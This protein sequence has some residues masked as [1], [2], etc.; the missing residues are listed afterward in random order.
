MQRNMRRMGVLASAILLL[1]V[2]AAGNAS[3]AGTTA[4][5]SISNSATVNFNV[6]GVGQTVESSE[7][8]NSVPG[9]G[10]ATVFTVD[11]KVD[12]L[13]SE[14]GG[15]FT[16]TRPGAVDQVLTFTVENEGNFVQDFLLT[17]TDGSGNTFT[18]GG[19]TDTDDFDATAV[20]PP[21]IWIDSDLSGDFD[22]TL[23]TE[24]AYLDNLAVDTP[25]TVFVVRNIAGTEVDG[26]ASFITLDAQAVANSGTP[27]SPGAPLT[28]D[29]GTA[30]TLQDAVGSEQIVFADDAATTSVAD[31]A[32]DGHHSAIDGYIIR[33]AQLTIQKTA[34]V[35]SDPFSSSNP[36]AIPGAIVE[37]TIQ[38]DNAGAATETAAG[39]SISDD[40]SAEMGGATPR[41]AIV[42]AAYGAQA[43]GDDIELV[44]DQTGASLTTELSIANDADNG[45]FVGNIL[46]VDGIALDPG[47]FARVRFR[48]QIQ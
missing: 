38:I 7:A 33:S 42:L 31:I 47:E 19:V 25:F 48:V 2:G 30:N 3:A 4:G 45:Q 17:A 41:L 43:A 22:N 15:S 9:G 26:A 46:T 16:T 12:V 8:G 14:V 5:T 18:L 11:R 40:L 39:I 21:G 6:Q 24:V 32:S 34:V 1:V 10:S 37:Y 13:V 36:K 20:T 29:S 28:D 44:T 35:I 27:A 23:D